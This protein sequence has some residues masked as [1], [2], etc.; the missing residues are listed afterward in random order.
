MKM[1]QKNKGCGWIYIMPILYVL[2]AY[3]LPVICCL[4][5]RVQEE[6]LIRNILLLCFWGFPV[7][8]GIFNLIVVLTVGRR[9]TRLQLLNCARIVKYGL[10]PFFVMGG[11]LIALCLLLT[12]TPVVI[13][14]FI[15]PAMALLL[16]V[17][18]WL[19]LVGGAPY[20][21]A[22]IARASKDKVHGAV[23]T[24]FAGIFQFFFVMD[25]LFLIILACFDRKYHHRNVAFSK[26][27]G[28]YY[29]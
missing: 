3:L 2:S 11:I 18:G 12:F 21:I 16:S 28:E 14:I 17:I 22:Y 27:N 26:V 15:G 20:S 5:S 13:M 24:A 23:L 9:A 25:V 29:S 19:I 6:G 10:V 1:N 8:G 7:I 4:T